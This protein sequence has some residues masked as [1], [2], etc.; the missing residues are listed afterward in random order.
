MIWFGDDLLERFMERGGWALIFGW[1]SEG[2]TSKNYPL[3]KVVLQLLLET[4]TTIARLRENKFPILI[5]GLSK[6]CEDEGMDIDSKS[7][8][9][10]F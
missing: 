1:T 7:I 3:L 2:V 6:E 9:I 5:K 4:P 10:F 8:Y